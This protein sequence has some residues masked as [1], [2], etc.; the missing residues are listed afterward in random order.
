MSMRAPASSRWSRGSGTGSRASPTSRITVSC[1]AAS[2]SGMFG[3]PT[4]AASSCS[5]SPR[6]SSPSALTRAET[7]RGSCSGSGSRPSRRASAN[8]WES[9]FCSARSDSAAAVASRQRASRASTRSRVSATP[10]PRRASAARTPSGSRRICRRSSTGGLAALL[11]DGRLRAGLGAGAALRRRGRLV[12]AAAGVLGQ[13]RGDVLCLAPDDDVLRHDRAGE[14]AVADR[15]E[16]GVDVLLAD[17]EVRPVDALAVLD[18]QR[19]ALRPDDVEVVAARAA[20]AEELRAGLDVGRLLADLRADRL[21]PAGRERAGE[22][23]A[24]DGEG[25]QR[26]ATARHGRR[27]HTQGMPLRRAT[28]AAAAALALGAVTAGCGGDDVDAVARAR[29]V[30]VDLREYRI[31]PQDWRVAAGDIR[32]VAR[33][34]GGPP[35]Q[36]PAGA[37]PP[38]GGGPPPGSPP[39]PPPPTPPP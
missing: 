8:C 1:G 33:H 39:T 28:V 11:R 19:A 16:D 25:E 30:R 2:S 38:P 21:R 7:A 6:A 13:E 23:G 32:L 4:S 36:P 10:G 17:V 9:S 14:A 12:L 15:V 5:C 18:L 31:D 29:V 3:S 24:G 37:G 35:P 26:G 34:G 27:H 20:V 22:R